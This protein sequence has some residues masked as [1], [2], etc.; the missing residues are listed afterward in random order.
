MGEDF[1]GSTLDPSWIVRSEATGAKKHKKAIYSV[2]LDSTQGAEDSHKSLRIDFDFSGEQ[3][4]YAMASN[5]KKR[6]LTLYNGAEFFVKGTETLNGQFYILTS[7]PDNPNKIDQWTGIITIDKNWKKI[8]IPFD[9]LIISRGW[10]KGG[11]QKLGAIP[12]D[13]VM[14]LNRLEGIQFGIGSD[15]NEG[16]SGSMWIDKIRLYSD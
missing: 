13:Q 10:I 6:D 8:R 16:L 1:E 4:F 11:A 9:Q 2:H 7:H 15:K 12:G 14:R 5:R 3:D